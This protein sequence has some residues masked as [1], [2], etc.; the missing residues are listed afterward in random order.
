MA[1]FDITFTAKDIKSSE[2]HRKRQNFM[3]LKKCACKC[4]NSTFFFTTPSRFS[5]D[6]PKAIYLTG[7][8]LSCYELAREKS[9]EVIV[10]Y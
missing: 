1:H 8:D 7:G 9:A 5:S 2:L 10:L 3:P 4:M 6:K